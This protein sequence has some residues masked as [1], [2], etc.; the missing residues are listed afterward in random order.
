MKRYIKIS[1]PG[2]GDL[3]LN[4]ETGEVFQPHDDMYI[5]TST[6]AIKARTKSAERLRRIQ[7]DRV[8]PAYGDFCWICFPMSNSLFPDL[9]FAD[10]ARLL[11]LATYMG[12]DGIL[13][14]G[15]EFIHPS[16]LPSLLGIQP[17]ETRNF[18][19]AASQYLFYEEDR[20]LRLRGDIFHRGPLKPNDVAVAKQNEMRYIRMY[21][22][23]VRQLY[24]SK[25]KEDRALLRFLAAFFTLLH[26]QRNVLCKNC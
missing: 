8:S 24:E 22:P 14:K 3:Y 16:D 21:Y 9:S 2:S 10:S 23:A 1:D 25:N 11:Y 26:P 7:S 13:R 4:P 17:R 5:I 18:R 20:C 15:E 6:R 19:S 12:Y